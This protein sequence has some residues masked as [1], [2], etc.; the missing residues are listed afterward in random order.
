MGAVAQ[1]VNATVGAVTGVDGIDHSLYL[2]WEAP[3]RNVVG[4]AN[5]A[6]RSPAIVQYLKPDVVQ[7]L[8]FCDDLLN[9]RAPEPTVADEDL[10][11]LKSDACEILE[12]VQNSGLPFELKR[13]L[14]ETPEALLTAV[15]EYR[16][17]VRAAP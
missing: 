8:E 14:S 7:A 11:S 16:L 6:D 3:I 5:Y 12:E 15:D 9:E 1:L 4:F 2:R 17:D 10:S 13:Y